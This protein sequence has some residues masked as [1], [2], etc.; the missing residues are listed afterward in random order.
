MWY[1]WFE[2]A[3][4]HSHESY[5]DQK[6]SIRIWWWRYRIEKNKK[7]YHQDTRSFYSRETFKNTNTY[8]HII[9]M[10]NFKFF[11]DDEYFVVLWSSLMK[12]DI[13]HEMGLRN[14]M[15]IRS[16][17]GRKRLDDERRIRRRRVVR[18][19]A[20]RRRRNRSTNQ[21]IDARRSGRWL[22]WMI[23]ERISS[24]DI[25]VT[26]NLCF[27]CDFQ[28][29]IETKAVSQYWYPFFQSI[30]VDLDYRSFTSK[31]YLRMF[32]TD[33][34]GQFFLWS[35]RNRIERNFWYYEHK[36]VWSDRRQSNILSRILY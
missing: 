24:N 31:S 26:R 10:W 4:V 9:C 36:L 15:Q 30:Y 5:D 23:D 8:Y 3:H 35:K 34:C 17:R 32:F 14:F 20:S 21:W 18:E 1:P 13:N 12:H 28:R 22:P 11:D 27:E 33:V 25:L 29:E 6:M 19:S 16:I 2:V 7:I